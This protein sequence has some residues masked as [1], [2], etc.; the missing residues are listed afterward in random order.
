MFGI[1]TSEFFIILAVALMLL[2][3]KKLPEMARAIGRAIGE[4]KKASSEMK[5]TL[6]EDE[7]LSEI[8]KTFDDAVAEGH[9][10]ADLCARLDG[11]TVHLPPLRERVEEVPY[12]FG[13]LLAVH[14]VGNETMPAVQPGLIEQ[15]CLH[16]L[17]F[18]V[19]ELSLLAKRL[20]VLH[21]HESTLGRDHLP[22]RFLQGTGEPAAASG[23]RAPEPASSGPSSD[24]GDDRDDDHDRHL[25]TVHA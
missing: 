20:I 3:P 22:A 12:L 4:F 21:G 17:P 10:R 18:N 5:K 8:K 15:L 7:R 2:G 1:S 24:D 16:D 23:A 25:R 11:L 9:F 6:Q 19:R 13:K 14:S